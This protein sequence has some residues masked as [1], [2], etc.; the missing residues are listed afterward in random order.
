MGVRLLWQIRD[1]D[2]NAKMVS[3]PPSTLTYLVP[4]IGIRPKTTGGKLWAFEII[5]V[6]CF[7]VPISE[8]PGPLGSRGR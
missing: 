7:H 5:T 2:T 4:Y 3:K 1:R 6:E 8:L